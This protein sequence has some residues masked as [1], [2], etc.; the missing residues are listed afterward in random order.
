VLDEL[1]QGLA[2]V[3]ASPP[4][5]SIL[6]L[7]AVVSLVGMPYTVLMPIFASQILHGG[8]HTLGFLMGAIGVGALSG[9]VYLASRRTVLGLGRLIPQM[10]ALFGAGLLGFALSR[11]LWLSLA[12][13]LATG[14]GFIAQMAASNTLLQT[15]VDDDKRGRVMSFYTMAFMGT[16]PF[17]SLL[18]GAVAHRFGAPAALFGG[19]IGCLLAAA[20]FARRLPELRRS[21]LP[22]YVRMGILPEMTAALQSATELTV[23]PQR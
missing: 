3:G 5:R 12:L 7:L 2:Y 20:W 17:G 10:A 16:A 14:G 1:R 8:P 11:N 23:P 21:V 15:L 4:I 18:A 13:L 6:L 19:G 9:A 22:I